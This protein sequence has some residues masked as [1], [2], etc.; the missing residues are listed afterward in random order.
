MRITLSIPDA[1]A[2]QFQASVPPR[3]RSR[4]VTALLT[5]ELKRKEN[6]LKAACIAAN[7]DKT[8]SKEIEEWQSFEDALDE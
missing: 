6:A 7:R 2:K 4:L 3:K 8:L 5:K 1:I